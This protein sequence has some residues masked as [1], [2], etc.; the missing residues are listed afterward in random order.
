MEGMEAGS[1]FWVFG[2]CV[3]RRHGT[4]RVSLL[5]GGHPAIVFALV[6]MFTT[7]PTLDLNDGLMLWLKLPHRIT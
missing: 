5:A 4:L 2:F 3:G 7:P 6:N 1:G